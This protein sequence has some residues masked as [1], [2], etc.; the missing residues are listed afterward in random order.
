MEAATGFNDH[1]P[2]LRSEAEA[3]AFRAGAIERCPEHDHITLD[4]DDEEANGRAYA[5]RTER[6]KNGGLRCERQE[7][8]DAI[9][10]VL[11]SSAPEC[12]E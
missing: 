9:H 6:W 2:D 3:I 7:F 4:K 11:N 10:D 5:T 8:M 12:P 1:L